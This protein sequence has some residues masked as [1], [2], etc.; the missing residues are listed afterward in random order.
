[1]A[2]KSLG[3]Q[4]DQWEREKWMGNKTTESVFEQE[5]KNRESTTFDEGSGEMH[6]S[7]RTRAKQERGGARNVRATQ[8]DADGNRHALQLSAEI[9]GMR[10]ST[11]C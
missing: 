10:E 11:S 2:S 3:N 8:G 4:F 1:M 9:K 7:D 6:E 5:K